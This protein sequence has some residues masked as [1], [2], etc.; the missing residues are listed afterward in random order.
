M[1]LR[2]DRLNINETK[3]LGSPRTVME[4]FWHW[5]KRSRISSIA[6][7]LSIL[8]KKIVVYICIIFAAVGRR[9]TSKIVSRKSFISIFAFDANLENSDQLKNVTCYLVVLVFNFCNWSCHSCPHCNCFFVF[10]FTSHCVSR[11]KDNVS[12]VSIHTE[13]YES[14]CERRV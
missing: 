4:K 8:Q 6:P 2:S 11:S 9:I 3:R 13:C 7:G 5:R 10:I 12:T 14:C 1:V